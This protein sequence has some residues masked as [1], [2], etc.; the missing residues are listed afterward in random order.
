MENA[1]LGP[2][3]AVQLLINPD[4]FVYEGITRKH[5]NILRVYNLPPMPPIYLSALW[6]IL[7]LEL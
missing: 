6:D 5:V 1:S 2:I 7:S 4:Q 3:E